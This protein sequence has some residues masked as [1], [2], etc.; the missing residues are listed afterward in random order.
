MDGDSPGSIVGLPG[1]GL[2]PRRREWIKAISLPGGQ[3]NGLFMKRMDVEWKGDDKGA[4]II[5]ASEIEDGTVGLCSG[6][7]DF[8]K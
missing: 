3:E 7:K 2:R 5:S 6:T 8:V 1:R 4:L